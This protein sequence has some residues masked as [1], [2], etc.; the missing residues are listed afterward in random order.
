MGRGFTCAF[1]MLGENICFSATQANFVLGE[2]EY[3][4]LCMF[5]KQNENILMVR[6]TLIPW[7]TTRNQTQCR[8]IPI[9]T[10]VNRSKRRDNQKVCE[11][12]LCIDR[13]RMTLTPLF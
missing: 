11:K 4:A 2:F 3:C 10:P 6:F 7:L 13:Q 5:F 9:V 12:L 1:M 8:Y